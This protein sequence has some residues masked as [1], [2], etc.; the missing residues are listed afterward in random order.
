VRE[1]S[2][3]SSSSRACLALAVLA[4]LFVAARAQAEPARAGANPAIAA[5]ALFQE[6]RQEMAGGQ[7]AK[8]CVKLEESERLAPAP[9]TA[10]NLADCYTHIGRVASA[11]SLFRDVEGETQAAGQHSRAQEAG[12]RAAKLEP[13]LPRIRIEVVEASDDL[14]IRR[15]GLVVG[16]GQWSV[17]VPVDLG[18]HVITA[19]APHK[20][21]WKTALNVAR[22]AEVL[23]VTIPALSAA[24]GAAAP[25]PPMPIVAPEARAGIAPGPPPASPPGADLARAPVAPTHTPAVVL[26]ATGL[27][28]LVA[29]GVTVAIAV[30]IYP[31]CPDGNCSSSQAYNDSTRA[32]TLGNIATGLGVA[33][34]LGVGAGAILWWLE[35][36]PGPDG[37]AMNRRDWDVAVRAN[38]VEFQGSW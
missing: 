35:S 7:Y 18:E 2:I 4:P 10:F 28:L 3:A 30:S 25:A 27:G 9:G 5:E 12:R 11:W 38:G 32:R 26:G 37:S 13:S 16:R 21:P 1:M 14:E 31:K 19:A 36:R 8:A 34:A 15:D 33:G 20:Q 24:G 17:E 23:V 22:P 6:A 29:A